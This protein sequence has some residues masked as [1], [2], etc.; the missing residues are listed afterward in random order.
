M[1]TLSGYHLTIPSGILVEGDRGREPKRTGGRG[2]RE[3]GK[4]KG[5]KVVVRF[6]SSLVTHIF[7]LSHTWHNQGRSQD[8][9]K[10]GGGGHTVSNI[11]AMALLL[12][13]I[14][15]CLLKKGLQRGGHGHPRTPPR[16]ALDNRNQRAQCG[17]VC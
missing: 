2:V 10:G 17:M 13:N 11:I 1:T 3:D 16:Y 8:A 6:E 9:S 12:R 7:S 5:G 4:R 14:V 15:G